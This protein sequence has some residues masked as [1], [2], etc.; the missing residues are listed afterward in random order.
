MSTEEAKELAALSADFRE[1]LV[2]Q[3]QYLLAQ[4][5]QTAVCN[6]KHLIGQ[7][8]CS[9]LLR[10]VDESGGPSLLI[11]QENLAKILGVQRASVSMY[12]SELQQTLY[13]RFRNFVGHFQI[14]TLSSSVLWQIGCEFVYP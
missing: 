7:G 8:L 4:A 3:Q 12:A 14:S 13:A 11:T 10:A 1:V 2:A 9:W 6:A 5:R